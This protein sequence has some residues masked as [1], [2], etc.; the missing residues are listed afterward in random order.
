M[1]VA[2]GPSASTF[3]EWV[4]R[5]GEHCETLGERQPPD[6]RLIY[7]DARSVLT[8]SDSPRLRQVLER[9]RRHGALSALELGPV[10]WIRA[11]GASRT[12]FRL[13]TVQPDV[14]F[15]SEEPAAELASPLEGIAAIPV[16]ITGDSCVVHGR[17]VASPSGV[18][19]DPAVFAAVF[20]VA[21]VEG[22]APVEAAGRA[23]LVH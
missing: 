2:A 14:L 15:A 23:V 22:Q 11:Q 20:C 5:L 7:M 10:D 1:F 18:V 4:A 19:I 8:A 21:L 13:A 9:S 3:S 6:H 12:A 16:L 17:R